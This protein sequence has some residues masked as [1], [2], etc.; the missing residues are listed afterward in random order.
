MFETSGRGKA[1]GGR[2]A[3]LQTG[4][5]FRR[6]ET[7]PYFFPWGSEVADVS[8]CAKFVEPPLKMSQQPA[9]SRAETSHPQVLKQVPACLVN[10]MNDV[11][12]LPGNPVNRRL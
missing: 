7:A 1:K 9:A 5:R 8:S 11:I 3:E 4:V 2:I 12:S 6:E 10:K